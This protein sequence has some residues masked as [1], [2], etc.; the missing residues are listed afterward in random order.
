MRSRPLQFRS[1]LAIALLT[2]GLTPAVVA[3]EPIADRLGPLFVTLVHRDE[4]YGAPVKPL[5]RWTK[6]VRVGAAGRRF[7]EWRPH[8]ETWLPILARETGHDIAQATDLSANVL[9][10]FAEGFVADSQR[11]P[12]YRQLLQNVSASPLFQRMA[13]QADADRAPCW[14][15]TFREGDAIHSALAMISETAPPTAQR[16]CFYGWLLSMTGMGLWMNGV[17]AGLE[18]LVDISP[19]GS[20]ILTETGVRLLR[21]IYDPRLQVGMSVDET[22]PL[23]PALLRGRP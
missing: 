9:V 18:V 5:S 7:E 8:F 2:I 10:L 13:A 4:T 1:R 11:V 17:G 16:A 19:N 6:P 22:L 21:M 15:M 14:S 23:L 20:A 12:L 3:A